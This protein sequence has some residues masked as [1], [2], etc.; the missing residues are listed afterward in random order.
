M[1]S[2]APFFEL[3]LSAK[4]RQHFSRMKIEFPIFFTFF[5]EFC[6]FCWKFWWNFVLISRQIPEKSDS[7]SLFQ[8]NL[9]KPIRKL[10]KIL[11]SVKLI[12]YHSILFIRVLSQVSSPKGDAGKSQKIET[13]MSLTSTWVPMRSERRLA[14]WSRPEERRGPLHGGYE[15]YRRRQPSTASSE[16]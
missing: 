13:Y 12:Q 6:I 14:R 16:V 5:V 11:K 3:K 4:N 10:P 8:L 2:F 1:H 15:G 9:R 7:V